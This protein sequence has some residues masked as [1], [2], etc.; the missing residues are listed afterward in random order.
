MCPAPVELQQLYINGEDS[1]VGSCSGP[2]PEKD[3]CFEAWQKALVS[4]SIPDI[5]GKLL[6]MKKHLY[7]GTALLLCLCLTLCACAALAE[8][9]P[10]PTQLD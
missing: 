6:F 1:L 10:W 3:T 7:K 2:E 8:G 9:E 5:H 4:L